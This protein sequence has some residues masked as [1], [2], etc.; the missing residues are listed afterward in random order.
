MTAVTLTE[1]TQEAVK[2][3]VLYGTP[4]RRVKVYIRCTSTSGAQNLDLT[5]YNPNIADIEGVLY[6]TDDNA[7]ATVASAATWSTYTL[8][9][10]TIGTTEI[11]LLCT[12]T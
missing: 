6:H 10:G 12:L 7:T 4:S 2:G 5:T 11:G 3:N 8:T 9:I 1:F